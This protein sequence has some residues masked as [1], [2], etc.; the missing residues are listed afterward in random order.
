MRLEPIELMRGYATRE[1]QG[2][3][4]SPGLAESAVACRFLA[5][6]PFQTILPLASHSQACD[7]LPERL[8][9]HPGVDLGRGN[10]PVTEGSL[11]QTEV[12]SLAEE[13]HGKGMALMPSSA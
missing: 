3:A 9:L 4:L 12:V 10:V 1:Q 11:Y 7:G 2:E 8:V 13:P 5:L 6:T